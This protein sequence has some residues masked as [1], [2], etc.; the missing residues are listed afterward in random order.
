MNIFTSIEPLTESVSSIF[1]LSSSLLAW[2]CVRYFQR[3][4]PAVLVGSTKSGMTAIPTS[5]RG[6]LM[7]KSATRV[8]MTVATLLTMLESVPL[9]TELTPLIS[10]FMRVMMSPCFS[11]VKNE[12]GMYCRCLYI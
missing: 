6:A 7:L 10:V 3:V 12:C 8:V 5:A 2:L 1:W 4:R 9:M 11:V